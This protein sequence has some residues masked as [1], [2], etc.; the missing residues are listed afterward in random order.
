TQ[1]VRSGSIDVRRRCDAA[2][3]VNRADADQLGRFHRINIKFRH[4]LNSHLITQTRPHN[5]RSGMVDRTWASVV[6]YIGL[7]PDRSVFE[8][9]HR[10]AAETGKRTIDPA[11]NRLVV[12]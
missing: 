3:D 9:D 4:A 12:E 1:R 5:C 2:A 8:L 6:V 11:Y 10:S 7:L